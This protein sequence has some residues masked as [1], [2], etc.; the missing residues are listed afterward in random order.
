MQE[1]ADPIELERP[2]DKLIRRLCLSLSGYLDQTQIDQCIHA[3]EVGAAAHAGQFRKSGEAYICHPVSV[4]ISLAEMHMDAN[5][6][7]A[8]ILHDVIED[9]PVSKKELA[10][11][12]GKEVA[13]LVDGVTK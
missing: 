6:I 3:Y 8:A 7:M 12:F 5:G 11:K 10:D 9:T 13:E 2:Q 4:A 1:I